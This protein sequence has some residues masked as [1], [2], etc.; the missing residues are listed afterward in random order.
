MKISELT[1]LQSVDLDSSIPVAIA[2]QTMRVT[3]RQLLDVLSSSIAVFD[4]IVTNDVAVLNGTTESAG[5]VVY[6]AKHHRFA[7]RV[8][9]GDSYAYYDKW[10]DMDRYMVGPVPL[11]TCLFIDSTSGLLYRYDAEQGWCPAGLTTMQAEQLRLNTPI[12]VADE[13]AMEAMIAAGQCIDGQ[14]Y[15]VA[16]E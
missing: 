6:L 13:E 7:Y 12:A 9:S 1:Q 5:A 8:A 11:H 14:L 10:T 15:Y 16:E 3:L 4:G 2:G